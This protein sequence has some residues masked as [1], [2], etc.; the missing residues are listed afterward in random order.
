MFRNAEARTAGDVIIFGDAFGAGKGQRVTAH[1]DWRAGRKRRFIRLLEQRRH[2]HAEDEQCQPEM[3]RST[4]D[5][6][7]A[8]RREKRQLGALHTA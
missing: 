8:K 4:G 2:A 6:A 5:M 7:Q 3:R 1:H